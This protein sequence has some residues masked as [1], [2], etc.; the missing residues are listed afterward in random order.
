MKRLDG[1][2]EIVRILMSRG[3]SPQVTTCNALISEFSKCHGANEGY[4]V[5]KEVFGVGNAEN[6]CSKK[7]VLKVR[8]NVHTFNALML[9]FYRE[10]L[11]KKVREVWCEMESLG[12]V[13]NSYSYSVLMA[14]FCEE[15]KV[16]EA[17]DL[18]AD[19][20]VKGL[21]PDIVAYNTMIDGLCKSGEITRAEELFREMGLS[22]IKATCV[23]YENLIY[24]YCK[25]ADI[26]SAMLIYRDMCRKDFRPQSLTMEL[27]IRGLCDKGTVLKAFE[28]M[29]TV[30]DFGVCPTETS[31]EFLIKGLCAEG[32]M[33]EALKLQAE[34]VGKGFKPNLE[35]YGAFIDGYSRQG[36]EEMVA[37]LRKEVSCWEDALEILALDKSGSLCLLKRKGSNKFLH[38]RKVPSPCGLIGSWLNAL[39]HLSCKCQANQSFPSPFVM[40]KQLK[41]DPNRVFQ[42]IGIIL[43][44]RFEFFSSSITARQSNPMKG[45]AWKSAPKAYDACFN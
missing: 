35:I 44:S 40:E 32:K 42:F 14:A 5:Y 6:E 29:K 18:W 3:I 13:P 4:E 10:G 22:G 24:G 30:R 43:I 26:D 9:C 39:G 38:K 15:G 12:C 21:E 36:N 8:P 45:S 1:S 17:E 33:E 11:P 7:R 19:M 37:M 34:M 25:V 16:S 20:K 31:Y 23:T 41:D 28:I 27:L 2:I